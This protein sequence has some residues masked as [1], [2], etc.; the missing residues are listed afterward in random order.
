MTN[1]MHSTVICENFEYL[2]AIF[3]NV[4]RSLFRNFFTVNITIK[5]NTCFGCS[6]K[7]KSRPRKLFL[8]REVLKI[9]SFKG[10]I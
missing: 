10:G 5:I 3:F 9:Y 2:N 8:S 6:V 7:V 4:K 1:L